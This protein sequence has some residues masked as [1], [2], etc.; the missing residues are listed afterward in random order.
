MKNLV[1]EESTSIMPDYAAH[2]MQH[3]N[4]PVYPNH[5]V[6]A[7]RSDKA[8]M[9]YKYERKQRH[10]VHKRQWGDG[11]RTTLTKLEPLPKQPILTPRKDRYATHAEY[12]HALRDYSLKI[13]TLHLK[14]ER[15]RTTPA[16]KAIGW[17]GYGNAAQVGAMA[18]GIHPRM[19]GSAVQTARD[20]YKATRNRR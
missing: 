5:F 1:R 13:N 6:G 12:V 11:R 3:I 10:P 8:W 15:S 16:A 9:Q 7:S 14:A 2:G 17:F 4:M 18:A 19:T 20:I